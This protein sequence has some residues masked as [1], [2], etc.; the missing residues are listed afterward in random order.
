MKI[1]IAQ[2]NCTVGDL[3][4][5]AAKIAEYAQRAKAQGAEILLTPELS[6]CGYPPED[7]LL[8][9]GF[10]K[11]C[12]TALRSLAQQ[13][14]GITLIVGHPHEVGKRRYNA[15]SILRDGDIVATYHKHALPN[16]SVF[17]EERYFEHGNEPCLLE[18]G[19]V[20]FGINICADVW[21][22]HAAIRAKQAGAQMLLVLN[23]SPYHFNKQ[24]TRYDTIRE[25]IGDTGL[26]VVYANMVGGQDELVF[27][28]ASFVMDDR[29]ELTHQFPAF[30]E[31]L[32]FVEVQDG[33][34]LPGACDSV[35]KD[36]A[37]IYRALC[38]GVHD[39]ITKNR[40][41]GVLLGLS[42]GID[43]ALTLAVAVDALG[44]DK[45]LAVMMPS[46]YTAQISIDDSREMVKLLGV[47]YEELNI[48]PTFDAL[49]QT[50]A[51]MFKGLPADTT[52]ENLQA[53]I[54]GVLLMALSN[55]TGS[56]VL[57][58]GNKSEM[59]VGYATLYGDM[60]GGFA[61]LKDVSKTWVYRLS[62][63]RNTLG[64]VIPE[65]I[66]TR[67]PSAEL[68]PDQTDQDSLPPYDVLDA[69]MACYVEKNMNIAQIVAQGYA[70]T[71]VLR[72]VKLVRIAEYKRRQAPVGVRITDRGFGKDWRYPITVRYQ[73]E[74]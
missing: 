48:A 67:P 63:W 58:T 14:Q 73:D 23:A 61:V 37:G 68:K 38:L 12:A 8:R 27:D 64:R 22:E 36:E 35:V 20:K 16:H 69:I 41:P 59:T 21:H 70:E 2:I 34:L 42:G 4:G 3:A 57:T 53:R 56:L 30:D 50:L 17:D 31:V 46:P 40:F 49:Q 26:A 52:E 7:L 45:V 47:R 28:G 72:V 1:A 44:A 15:A 60:A 65:R 29:G 74:F 24:A 6:L 51:P 39:Y 11:A 54:R 33:K 71:D 5:N 10:F 25:R 13:A 62:N 43:S 18:M 32:G 19:G 9:S 55:K 66:I